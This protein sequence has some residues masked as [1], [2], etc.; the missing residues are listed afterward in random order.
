CR[1]TVTA[2]D[3]NPGIDDP[4]KEIPVESIT[5]NKTAIELEVGD[6]DN[7]TATVLPENATN[8]SVTWGVDNPDVVIVLNGKVTA[9][10][11]GTAKIVAKA[12]DKTAICTVTVKAKPI[13]VVT[14]DKYTLLLDVGATATLTANEEV[15]W[16]SGDTE[17]AS[18]DNN[19]NI[20]AIARGTTL[21]TASANGVSATCA[22][23][24]KYDGQAATPGVEYGFTSDGESSFVRG[25]GSATAT[26]IVIASEYEG[27]PV[28]FI[29][30]GAFNGNKNITS[31]IIPDSVTTIQS[32]AFYMCSNL[33]S[34]TIG[35]GVTEIE[36]KAFTRCSKLESLIMTGNEETVIG[37]EAFYYCESLISVI[38]SNV[39]SIGIVAFSGC[40]GLTHITIG[41]GLTS[42][43]TNAFDSCSSLTHI[44]YNGTVEQWNAVSKG[45]LWNYATGVYTLHCTD[46]D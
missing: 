38:I 35:S 5:I 30:S 6:E 17:I 22:V 21:I 24:V 19:G 29:S 8:K 10:G 27:K 46:G 13:P 34:V 36:E 31:V 20:T 43:G 25:I 23:T 11:E 39:K 1:V 44:T 15:E 32:K 3:D 16:T 28:T 33:T 26:D 2:A 37:Q 42:L 4:D 45:W 14:L 7:L 12:G 18:V 9:M 41:N 40:T